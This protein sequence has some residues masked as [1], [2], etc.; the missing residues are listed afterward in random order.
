MS[1]I[2]SNEWI[3]GDGYNGKKCDTSE[4]MKELYKGSVS[5]RYYYT[6]KFKFF[7]TKFKKNHIFPRD[8]PAYW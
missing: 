6:L 2:T 4:Y 1:D 5:L 8:R 3:V 7:H